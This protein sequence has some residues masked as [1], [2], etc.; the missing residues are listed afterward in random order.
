MKK[1][2]KGEKIELLYTNPKEVNNKRNKTSKKKKGNVT[3]GGSNKNNNAKTINLDNEIIIGLTPKKEESK[4][5]NTKTKRVRMDGSTRPQNNNKTT[6]K[7]QAKNS[8]TKEVKASSDKNKKQSKKKKIGVQIFKWTSIFIFVTVAIIIFLMSSVF[9]IKNI[10]ITNNNKISSEQIVKLSG[11]STGINMFKVSNKSIR[12]GIKMNPYI[13]NV[14]IKRNINGTIELEIEERIAT[15]M[16]KF[17]NAYVYINN[18]GY[19]LEITETPLE[20]PQITG[21]ETPSELIE[22]G[23]RLTIEDLKKLEDVIKIIETA[24]NTSLVNQITEINISD[25]KNY[26]L[27]ITNESKTV[28]FGDI[29]NV[30]IKLL[31][32]EAVIEQEKGVAGE[33]YFQD[34]EKTVFKEET[35]R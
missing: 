6:S 27:T 32:I 15:Y 10:V 4:K 20:L 35:K 31:K 3:K 13:E 8:G 33:I 11:L 16:L 21:F 28:E 1:R 19:I 22:E 29:T 26:I 7:K 17:A 9:N 24:K 23:K 30:N 2:A 14:K 18:Q 25:S 34:S 5:K 12:N